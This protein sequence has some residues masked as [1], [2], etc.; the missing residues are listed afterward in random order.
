MKKILLSCLFLATIQLCA[1][2]ENDGLMMPKKNL[3]VGAIYQNSSWNQYWEGTFKR[4][5]LNLGTVSSNSYNFNA[6]YG[7]TN[8]LNLIVGVPYIITKA[9]AGT[10]KGQNGFQDF[11]LTLKYKAIEKQNGK[12]LYS[13][14]GFAGFSVP[15]TDYPADYLP[16]N[17]G[18]QSKTATFRLM[19]DFQNG[20]F[21]TTL[22]AAYMRRANIKIDRDSYFTTEFH[23]TNE[24]FMPDAFTNNFRIGY[25][26]DRLIAQ[27][28]LE[29]WY[30]LNGGFDITKN[31]M[32]F[33]SNTMNSSKI[34]LDAKYTF[35][36]ISGLALV[37]GYNYIIDGRNVGQSKSFYLGIF[38][39]INFNK[40]Q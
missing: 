39:N 31:N 21:F 10:L 38:Q 17:I 25:R 30:T 16:L 11:S 36:K 5:N 27:A 4:E 28:T 32:P 6:N 2:T 3:C 7:F 40:K 9:T 29:N 22:S 1:Q 8:K 35:K 12:S 37:G 18:L 26:S 20:K 13:L 15:M 34:G 24:V 23:Y 14:I 33:P 19:G